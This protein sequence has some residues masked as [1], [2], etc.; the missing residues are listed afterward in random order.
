RA[1]GGYVVGPGSTVDGRAYTLTDDQ[2]P[3]ALPAWLATRLT[4]APPPLPPARPVPV[5]AS[6]R[7]RY[8]QAA[9][10]AEC[11]KVR[12]AIH[13]RNATLYAAAVALGQ[14]VAG[15]ALTEDD[16]RAALLSG[17]AR[18]IGVRRFSEREALT[19][20][21]SGLRAGAN[22]PRKVAA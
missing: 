6:R 8:L 11:A 3:A 13:D 17:A 10:T 14:L 16:G 12:D 2:V 1:H 19:T 4:P 5:A 22:R 20:I 21:A 18:H 9:I 7:D 15:G